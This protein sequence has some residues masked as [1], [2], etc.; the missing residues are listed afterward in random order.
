LRVAKTIGALVVVIALMLVV[1][2]P[3]ALA[4]QPGDTCIGGAIPVCTRVTPQS[5][6]KPVGS[7]HTVTADTLVIVGGLEVSIPLP[8]TFTITSGPDAGLTGTCTLIPCT[9]TFTNN[10][11]P[12]TDT[13]VFSPAALFPA[14][15]ATV[16]F[17]EQ[18]PPT[19]GE[20]QQRQPGGGGGGVG[21]E[22]G[23][24][25][26]ESGEITTENDYSISP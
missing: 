2:A 9:F 14:D 25:E 15:E 19:P 10:G 3:A 21:F 5:D 8:G 1:D 12:G 26:N 17:E 16:T 24:V 13:I 11:N 4:Q 6:T 20:G 18:N 22:I 7:T 23:D